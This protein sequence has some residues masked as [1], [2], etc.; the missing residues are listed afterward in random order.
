MPP[1]LVV[2]NSREVL[3]LFDRHTLR[4]V[5]QG[6]LHL[7]EEITYDGTTFLT[8]G[9]VCGAWWRGARDQFEEGFVV[10][11]IEG[12]SVSWRYVDYGWEATVNGVEK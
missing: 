7:V 8:G 12:D 3:G 10:L 6:H 11:D 9:S 2:T 1:N 5:L 4:L